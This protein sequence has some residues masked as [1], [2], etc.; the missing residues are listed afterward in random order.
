MQLESET[1]QEQHDHFQA[2]LEEERRMKDE[3]NHDV[4]KIREV[5][6]LSGPP[7][8]FDLEGGG[9]GRAYRPQL[10]VSP[11]N[12]IFSFPLGVTNHMR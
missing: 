9:V 11:L 10:T 2:L 3:A 5:N 8:I 6:H 7:H 12:F 4:L 1:A